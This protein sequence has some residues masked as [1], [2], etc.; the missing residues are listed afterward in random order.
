MS[1]KGRVGGITEKKGRSPSLPIGQRKSSP[2]PSVLDRKLGSTLVESKK[3]SISNPKK[4]PSDNIKTPR[5]L[6]PFKVTSMRSKPNQQN[7]TRPPF[8]QNVPRS[9]PPFKITGSTKLKDVIKSRPP[10]RPKNVL[11]VK[12]NMNASIKKQITEKGLE[13]NVMVSEQ[14]RKVSDSP[15]PFEM[16]HKI[17]TREDR[18]KTIAVFYDILMSGCDKKLMED[19]NDDILNNNVVEIE[20]PPLRDP[21]NLS[22]NQDIPRSEIRS[23][24]NVT[25]DGSVDQEPTNDLD[26]Q[27]NVQPNKTSEF[28]SNRLL[29]LDHPK[30]VD[31]ENEGLE[32]ER[33][34]QDSFIGSKY[35]EQIISNDQD[36]EETT[37]KEPENQKTDPEEPEHGE[38]DLKG[39][40]PEENEP[41]DSETQIPKEPE[42]QETQV[43]EEAEY[44]EIE[45]PEE[46][47]NKETEV[48]EEQDQEKTRVLEVP[49]HEETKEQQEIE[50]QKKPEHQ[51]TKEPEDLKHQEIKRKEAENEAKK[52]KMEEGGAKEEHFGSRIVVKKQEVVAYGKKE[53][54]K[55]Y[56]DVIEETVSKLRRQRK[57]ILGQES[58]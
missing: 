6:P 46:P 2:T 20:T 14:I 50:E 47:E 27:I 54:G 29:V 5:S 33:V 41:Q 38:M 4:Q 28:A 31:Q 37:Q 7:V 49:N 10:L 51:E 19:V 32:I 9:L 36:H 57:N 40:K 39:P 18:N 52:A 43:P 45:L 22:R 15:P 44:Q 24:D 53:T 23:R 13:N 25:I 58:W 55:A 1:T 48:Q 11:N 42:H 30:V 34:A 21:I 56:N 35:V 3:V 17:V 12:E 8:Q 16:D 26:N